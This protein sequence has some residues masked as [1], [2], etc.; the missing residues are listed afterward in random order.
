[1]QDAYNKLFN[2]EI[3]LSWVRTEKRDAMSKAYRIGIPKKPKLKIESY[4]NAIISPY[5]LNAH[6]K[7]CGG[8]F[9][10][11]KKPIHLSRI[12]IVT[13]IG[14]QCNKYVYSDETA[15]YC[16][17][18]TCT[19][20][21]GHFL[22]D[23][24][25]RLWYVLSEYR[26]TNVTYIIL[27]TEGIDYE[28]EGNFLEFLKLLGIEKK[29][30]VLSK[31]TKFKKVII[32]EKS[33]DFNLSIKENQMNHYYADEYLKVFDYVVKKATNSGNNYGTE[34]KY[35]NIYLIRK[36][37]R[38]A[39]IELINNLFEN[40]GFELIDP[41]EI[42]L[43]ELIFK[44][45]ECRT[46][47]YVSGTLQHNL[48][49]ASANVR[50][51]AIERRAVVSPM[52]I[53]IDILKRVKVDYID[54]H[55]SIIPDESYYYGLYGYTKELRK[56]MEDSKWNIPDSYFISKEYC[57]TT[58]KEYMK[59]YNIRNFGIS[60]VEF[61]EYIFADYCESMEELKETLHF[62]HSS[63]ED[64]YD[65]ERAKRKVKEM[66][67][68]LEICYSEWNDSSW[69][70]AFNSLS[71]LINNSIKRN[72][73]KFLIYPF[74]RNGMLLKQIL[75]EQYGIED[76][77]AFDNKLTSINKSIKPLCEIKKYYTGNSCIILTS[78][79]KECWKELS[80]YVDLL[81]VE[82]PFSVVYR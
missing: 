44:F 72:T 54:A 76:I 38:D 26:E 51:I 49:F 34:N 62:L 75:K 18:C 17:G 14:K 10:Q 42:S 63:R 58:I 67:I 7:V 21:W 46:I 48:M 5:Y 3:N 12:N 47:A 25:S 59:K 74:G 70:N 45:H 19:P 33:Y 50:A 4:D 71:G 78:A 22:I 8:A 60:M 80:N 53:D 9:D 73:S 29:V 61:D 40:N 65:I 39:G 52:Q 68:D 23:V 64:F 28:L 43:T 55:Y 81:E 37:E 35:R 77:I 16:G 32:P 30:R 15:V 31:A 36:E 24:V 69:W 27:G 57:E 82:G 79:I 2:N 13:P 20:H 1:M 6:S 66:L 56:Y 11:Y 41:V